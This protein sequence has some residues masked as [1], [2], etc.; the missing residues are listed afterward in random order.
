MGPFLSGQNREKSDSY[1]SDHPLPQSLLVGRPPLF[2]D[3]V[4][5][6]SVSFCPLKGGGKR[7]EPSRPQSPLF[8]CYFTYAMC[9]ESDSQEANS[10]VTGRPR[11]GN[12]SSVDEM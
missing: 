7:N 8:Q 1:R 3:E 4:P 6:S 11:G 10:V 12:E 5:N 2:G 9:P